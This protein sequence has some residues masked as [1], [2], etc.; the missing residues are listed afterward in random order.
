MAI[1]NLLKGSKVNLESIKKQ[2]SSSI[3]RWFNDIEFLRNYDV[4]PA[5]P[6]TQGDVEE[7]LLEYKNSNENYIFSIRENETDQIIGLC[8]FE[9][10]LWNNQNAV[11]YIGIGE[12]NSRGKGYGKEAIKLLIQFGFE[13]LNFHRIQLNVLEYNKKAINLYEKIG[14]KKEGVYR[15]YIYRSGKRYDMYLYGFLREEYNNK[16]EL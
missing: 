15:E 7:M 9:N 1:N 16:N 8:G 12:E 5:F 14:F 2:D 10:I 3:E 6:K 4:V 13:E 11:L